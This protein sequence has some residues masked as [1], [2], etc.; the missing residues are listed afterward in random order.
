LS[1]EKSVKAIFSQSPFVV[2]IRHRGP[3]VVKNLEPGLEE[4][5]GINVNL[6][7]RENLKENK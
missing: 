5:F 3:G 7:Q 4:V 2:A 1:I 6:L